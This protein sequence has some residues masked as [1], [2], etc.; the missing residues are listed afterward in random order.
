MKTLVS[1]FMVFGFVT[2]QAQMVESIVYSFDNPAAEI[3]EKYTTKLFFIGETADFETMSLE[4]FILPQKMKLSHQN[5][6][7]E[8]LII[9]KEGVLEV[10]LLNEKQTL[11]AGGIVLI[12]P[13]DEAKIASQGTATYYL[14][15][16]KAKEGGSLARGKENGGSFMTSWESREHKTHERGGLRNFYNKPTAECKRMEMHATNLNAGIK[17]HEPHTHRAAEIVLM[18]KGKSEMELGENI[19]HGE[20]GDIYFLGS[21]IPHAIKNIDSEQIQYFA[22]QFE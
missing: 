7:M 10:S 3:M 8:S 11:G 14:M 17:S 22:Y 9:V 13:G 18:I 2:A 4:A 1:L 5:R 16:Y 20:A 19:Y 21:N 12:M 15:K 6:R